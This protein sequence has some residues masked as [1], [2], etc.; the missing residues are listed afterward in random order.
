MKRS[1][2][3]EGQI[4]TF[5]AKPRKRGDRRRVAAR[6]G[7][8]MLLLTPLAEAIGRHVWAGATLYADDTPVPVLLSSDG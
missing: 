7:L 4:A 2:F 5:C 3:S 6:L 8:A 1:K